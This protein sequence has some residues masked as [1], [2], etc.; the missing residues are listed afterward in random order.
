[1]EQARQMR[2]WLDRDILPVGVFVDAP[3]EQIIELYREG[4]IGMAQLHGQEDDAYIQTL[5]DALRY[6]G[7]PIGCCENHSRHPAPAFVAG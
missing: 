6:S 5:K 7:H 1:M 3:I 4:I 2:G